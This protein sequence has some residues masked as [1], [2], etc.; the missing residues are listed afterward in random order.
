MSG[1][2]WHW[3]SA[4]QATTTRS[5]D[6]SAKVQSLWRQ[7]SNPRDRYTCDRPARASIEGSIPL[8]ADALEFH[9]A[10]FDGH[11]PAA[12][13]VALG[14][15]ARQGALQL[16]ALLHRA[17][18]CV[19]DRLVDCHWRSSRCTA[20]PCRHQTAALPVGTPLSHLQN[21]ETPGGTV[22]R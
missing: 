10:L 11:E 6:L 4:D 14:R 7:R 19:P 18:G 15:S 1:L 22:E 5:Q 16:G 9:R 20:A 8:A 3:R 12:L 2:R 13:L 21:S 17:P